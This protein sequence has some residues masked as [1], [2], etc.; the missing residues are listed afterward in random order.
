MFVNGYLV[1]S[2]ISQN[3]GNEMSIFKF[4]MQRLLHPSGE[5]PTK[6]YIRVALL[7]GFRVWRRRDIFLGTSCPE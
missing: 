2:L 6:C 5:N 3:S 4:G 7:P 1:W